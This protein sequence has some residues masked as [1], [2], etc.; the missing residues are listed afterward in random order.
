MMMQLASWHLGVELCIQI[1]KNYLNQDQ[2]RAVL[3]SWLRLPILNGS[4]SIGL[5]ATCIFSNSLI[6]LNILKH[7]DTLKPLIFH[8]GQMGN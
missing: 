6:Y 5:F 8:L 7:W 4:G 1:G 3:M 2:K